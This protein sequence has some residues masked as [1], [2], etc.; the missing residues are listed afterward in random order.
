MNDTASSPST[1]SSPA[2]LRDLLA[3]V[4]AGELDPGEA[5]RLLD[6][7]PSAPTL[8]R[9]DDVR[10]EAPVS[11]L[12]IHAGGVK[13]T[14]VADPTVDTAV[15]DGPHALRREG[16]VLVLDAPSED[17]FRT[18]PPPRF[19]G[20]VPT[21]WTGGRGQKVLVRVNPALPLTV[22][23]TACS[24]DISGLR[25]P[26]TL[27]GS[28]SSIKV[29]DH[30]GALHG[31]LAMGSL[32]VVAV[33]DAPSDLA[34]ELGSL[35]LRLMPGSDVTVAATSDLGEVKLPGAHG[36]EKASARQ[37]YVVGAGTHPFTVAVRLGSASVA[38]A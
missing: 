28:A 4:A 16:S 12:A 25:A 10:A 17:G 8:D 20:W 24:V 26:L 21:V 32:E 2:S 1:S 31:S 37:S 14:V 34:C 22:E 18:T 38:G 30:T 36:A 9:R 6:A 19:L 33:V 13:L 7:D 29:G 3:Q 11:A 35:D 15:A 27:G 23:A 5:A